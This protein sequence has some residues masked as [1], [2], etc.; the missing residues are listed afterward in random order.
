[1]E[2][3]LRSAMTNTFDP[4]PQIVWFKRDLRLRDHAALSEAALRGP[5][6]G[7]YILEPELI[8]SPEFDRSHF[9]FIRESL[10][11]LQVGL[12]KLGSELLVLH[13]DAVASL[14]KLWKISNFC[15]LWSHE[16][17]GNDLTYKRDIRIGEWC[18]KTSVEWHELRQFG[19]IRRLKTRSG[20]A[21]HWQR[22]VS[23]LILPIP[24][25]KHP[26]T[27]QQRALV[28]PFTHIPSNEEIGSKGF[29]KPEALRAGE[30]RAHAMLESFLN[31]RGVTYSFGM[32]SP[33][34]GFQVCSRLSP[35]IAWGNISLREVYQA[36][37]NRITELREQQE[38]GMPVDRRWFMSLNSFEARLRWHC[39]FIQKLETE[40][41]LEFENVMRAFNGMRESQFNESYFQAWCLG[42]TGYPMV[43]ACMRALHRG[44]WINFRMRAMLVSF[45]S[46]QLWLHWRKPALF[47]ARHFLD[48]EPGIHF[49]QIQMQAGTTGINT[50]RIYSPIKQVLDQDPNG[51]F[52]RQYLPELANV[53]SE[54]LAEPHK[55]PAELQ[56]NVGCIIGTHY[57]EPIVDHT[58]AFKLARERYGTFKKSVAAKV[59]QEKPGILKKHTKSSTTEKTK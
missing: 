15:E 1:M 55:M 52:I 39:H 59:K 28:Y 9:E 49:S 27:A 44:G 23:S 33:V 46:Y 2:V 57:P 10:M 35:Y 51:Q 38:F 25:I 50:I 34:S 26:L 29:L 20:W 21:P 6:L 4:K 13:G 32:S 18:K 41:A 7:V 47:L 53:P 24:S 30:G 36:T 42:Q 31:H 3:T 22:H 14:E 11:E 54:Y 56:R 19:V 16:E 43:D 40:P 12:R 8:A 5:V 37:R 45:A 17:T 48:F 58:T